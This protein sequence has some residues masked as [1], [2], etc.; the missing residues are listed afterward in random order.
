MRR[1]HPSNSNHSKIVLGIVVEDEHLPR[2]YA[3]IGV[4]NDDLKTNSHARIEV[5]NKSNFI[6]KWD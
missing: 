5:V 1:V 3:S 4:A 2:N 6:E